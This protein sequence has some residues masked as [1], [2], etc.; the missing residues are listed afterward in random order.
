M[1]DPSDLPMISEDPAASVLTCICAKE[2]LIRNHPYIISMCINHSEQA[3]IE[4]KVE[5]KESADQWKSTFNAHS[6]KQLL[7]LLIFY[8]VRF[9]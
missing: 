9:D 7:V 2:I 1:E 4:I 3:H 6:K 5:A 8:L